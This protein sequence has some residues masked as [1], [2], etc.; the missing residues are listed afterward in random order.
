VTGGGAI[1]LLRNP[2]QLQ[3]LRDD[4]SLMDQAVEEIIRLVTPGDGTFIRIALED[5]ELSG[6]TIPANS[7]VIAPI[8]SANR[9]ADVFED[10]DALNIHRT[11]NKHIGFS[12]GTHFCAGSALAR[13]EVQIAMKSLFA[14]FPT[15]RLAVDPEDLRWRKT[16]A[17]GGYEEIPVTW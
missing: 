17:L 3:Q 15:L 6:T 8:S 14:R 12:H 13:A 4:P 5:V 11:D 1:L 9:D 7:A 16:A 2:D 10:P